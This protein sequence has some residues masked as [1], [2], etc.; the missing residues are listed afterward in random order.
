MKTGRSNTTTAPQYTETTSCPPGA[1]GAVRRSSR[2]SVSVRAHLRFA[3]VP[4]LGP[5]MVRGVARSVAR[6]LPARL[7]PSFA[8]CYLRPTRYIPC[9]PCLV[10]Y[11]A[12][13]QQCIPVVQSSPDG[14]T[15]VWTSLSMPPRRR[16]SLASAVWAPSAHPHLAQTHSSTRRTAP[17]RRWRMTRASC[18]PRAAYC[19]ASSWD[20]SCR[21]ETARM[22]W[23]RAA[24]PPSFHTGQL[25]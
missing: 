10:G 19:R 14:C 22:A 3:L 7:R 23:T 1:E 25:T 17:R 11:L 13:N 5:D 20:V 6:S 15:A 12:I 9:S 2:V 18:G 24:L 21:H 16:R 4:L 8:A